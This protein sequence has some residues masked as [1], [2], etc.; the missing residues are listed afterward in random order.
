MDGVICA[1]VQKCKGAKVLGI[2]AEWMAESMREDRGQNATTWHPDP[3]A[4]TRDLKMDPPANHPA[5]GFPL[6]EN[7][8]PKVGLT[9]PASRG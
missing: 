4:E 2:G 8:C 5:S 9:G 7:L 1:K 3:T 6:S